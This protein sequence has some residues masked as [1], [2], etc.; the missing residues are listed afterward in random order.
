MPTK[1]SKLHSNPLAPPLHNRC[2]K[3]AGSRSVCTTPG[4]ELDEI[5]ARPWRDEALAASVIAEVE[6]DDV[7]VVVL[8]ETCSVLTEGVI[9]VVV[10]VLEVV[11]EVDLC[12]VLEVVNFFEAELCSKFFL[13]PPETATTGSIFSSVALPQSPFLPFMPKKGNVEEAHSPNSLSLPS[14]GAPNWNEPGSAV[15]HLI[16]QKFSSVRMHT[17]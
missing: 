8:L 6:G 14:K 7:V 11:V 5:S 4:K 9:V 12:V 16:A 13:S 2:E 10:V 3:M 1:S 15:S 17:V